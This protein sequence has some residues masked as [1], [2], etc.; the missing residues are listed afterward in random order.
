VT[1]YRLLLLAFPKKSRREFGDDME[2]MF[3]AQAREAKASG[4]SMVRFWVDAFA[5]A[6]WHGGLERS[7]ELAAAISRFVDAARRWRW[8]MQ[9]LRQ[10]LRYAARLMMRTPG[11]TSI[12]LLTLAIG[13][14]ANAAI[15][16]AVDALL[17]RP[18]PYEDPDRLVMIWEKRI[19]E[20]GVTNVVA[21]ADYLDWSRMTTSFESMAGVASGTADLTGAGEPVRLFSASVSPAFFDVLR[22]RMKLGRTFRVD[23][24]AMGRNRVAILGHGLWQRRFDGDPAAIGRKIVLNGNPHEIVGVLP[25]T[26]DYPDSAIEIWTPLALEGGSQPPSRGNHFLSVYARLN[27]GVTPDQ[28]RAEMDRLSAMLSEQYP[29]SN[30]THRAAVVPLRDELVGPVRT[31]L[32]LLL[33]A[34]GFVLLIACVN[35]ANLLLARAA[36]RRRE[37]AIRAAL[38][39]GR[40]RLAR[41]AL[42]E[43]LLLAVLGGVAGLLVARWGTGV[44]QQ[45]APRNVP[46]LGLQRIGI[47]PRVLLYSFGLSLVT[48]VVFGLLPAWHFASQG[49]SDALKDGARSR[50]GLRRRLRASLVVSEIALASLLLV[51]AGLSLRS[52]QTVL[53]TDAGISTHGLLTTLITLPQARYQGDERHAATFQR[54]EE[55][56]KAIPGVKSVGA[57]IALPLT[58]QDGR[59]SL[60][61][62][63]VPS[64]AEAPTRAHP[65][66]VTVDYFRTMSMQLVSGRTLAV[67]D[68]RDAPLVAVVNETMARRY[69]PGTSPIGRRVRLFDSGWREIVGVVRDVRHWGLERPVNPEMY[70]PMV[71][72][73]FPFM[74]FVFATDGDPASLTPAVRNALHEIDPDLPLSNVRTMDEVLAISMASRSAAMSVLA[75]FGVVAL[76]LAAAGIYGVMSHL[77]SLRTGEIGVRM[78]MGARR[79]EIMRLILG[80]GLLQAIVGLAIGLAAA[81]LLMRSFQA[82]LYEVSPADPVTLSAV[83]GVV[84]ATALLACVVPARRAMN[85][86]PVTALR[87]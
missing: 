55:R 32:L 30:R 41:Q 14:G 83:A 60:E 80:E 86:D 10:D 28:A 50:G 66:G 87:Q 64:T 4:A 58:S 56:F 72:L 34:V 24:A 21:P 63:G 51:G 38:G 29:E 25:Q 46:I 40:A 9:A 67:T 61:I 52:F 53:R 23:E 47:D 44:L 2:Q 37:I 59:R 27:D 54:I 85:V 20:G 7:T 19:A 42:T 43:S 57:T 48:G 26:F 49:L 18:L 81:V 35:V 33:A 15:F 75:T 13:I 69:W 65:R 71:Q 5:D 1:L 6:L 74:T 79:A 62:E 12:A 3:A 16:S 11:A 78:T 17:L 8:W 36:A 31:S 82:L 45:I 22:V 68:R 70:C 39:A 84:I 73:P 77:V 76:I